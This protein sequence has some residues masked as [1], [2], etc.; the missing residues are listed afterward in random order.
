M[1]TTPETSSPLPV[2][3][4]T[5]HPAHTVIEVTTVHE[6]AKP[7]KK[8]HMYLISFILLVQCTA[9]LLIYFIAKQQQQ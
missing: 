2:L 9:L 3:T 6:E 4:E 1:T 7:T 8:K 5:A